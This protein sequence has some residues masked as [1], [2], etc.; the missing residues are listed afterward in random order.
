MSPVSF[1]IVNLGQ[2]GSMFPTDNSRPSL[3][4]KPCKKALERARGDPGVGS[5]HAWDEPGVNLGWVR[6][7]PEVNLAQV[8]RGPKSLLF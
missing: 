7:G 4:F 5:A 1:I 6:R 3:L 2:G 8:R